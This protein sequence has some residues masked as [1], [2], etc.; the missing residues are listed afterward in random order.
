MIQVSAQ[1]MQIRQMLIGRRRIAAHGLSRLK[2]DNRNT[3]SMEARGNQLNIEHHHLNQQ[4]YL[5]NRVTELTRSS[6]R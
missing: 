6:T 2:T 1:R 5:M 3:G 4:H